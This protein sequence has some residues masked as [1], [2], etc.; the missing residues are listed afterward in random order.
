MTVV[1][2]NSAPLATS[3]KRAPSSW[4]DKGTCCEIDNVFQTM[5]KAVVNMKSN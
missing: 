5:S 1:C 4:P 2:V 3:F